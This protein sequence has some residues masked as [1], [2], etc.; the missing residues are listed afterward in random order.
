MAGLFYRAA[1]AKLI[2]AQVWY[3]AAAPGLDR[4]FR[5]EID[6]VV[7]RM[8]DNT[9]QFPTRSMVFPFERSRLPWSSTPKFDQED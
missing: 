5:A 3:E 8:A 2:D 7:R 1:R 4:R 6:S 9:R